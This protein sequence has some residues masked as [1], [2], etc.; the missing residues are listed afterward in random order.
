VTFG[1][2]TAERPVDGALCHGTLAHRNKEPLMRP[3]HYVAGELIEVQRYINVPM[4][5]CEQY[6]ARERRELWVNRSDAHR[7]EIK[8]VV[9]SRAMPARRGHQVCVLLRGGTVVG[10]VNL[11]T[12]R[13]VNFVRAD[14]PLLV[15]RCDGLAAF[16]LLGAGAMLSLAGESPALWLLLPL[17][18]LYPPVRALGRLLSRVWMRRRVDRGLDIAMDELTVVASRLQQAEAQGSR[19]TVAARKHLH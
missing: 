14:P 13:T 12:R 7:G 4:R 8:L 1:V 10:L 5:W 2:A 6:P 16:L 17:A 11:T 9:H 19:A 3:F 15:R 18:L